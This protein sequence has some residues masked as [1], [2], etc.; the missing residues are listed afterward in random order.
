MKAL[1]AAFGQGELWMGGKMEEEGRKNESCKVKGGGGW[2]EGGWMDGWM[3]GTEQSSSLWDK[4]ETI[5]S[6][7]Q[8]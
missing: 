7:L 2:T 3:D 5:S 6:F 4:G 1:G 8:H